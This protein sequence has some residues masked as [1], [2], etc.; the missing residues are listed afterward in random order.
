MFMGLSHD[1]ECTKK[2]YAEEDD[3][4]DQGTSQ[5]TLKWLCGLL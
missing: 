4:G 3:I 2:A 5:L 1:E